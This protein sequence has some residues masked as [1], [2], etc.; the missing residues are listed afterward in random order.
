MYLNEHE[1]IHKYHINQ[2]IKSIT[3]SLLTLPFKFLIKF[4]TG[5]DRDKN[6]NRPNA[7]RD[8]IPGTGPGDGPKPNSLSTYMDV[9]APKVRTLFV[10]TYFDFFLW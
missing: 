8:S 7:P 1:I 3:H 6:Q 9:D 2:T 4:F 5:N 10:C